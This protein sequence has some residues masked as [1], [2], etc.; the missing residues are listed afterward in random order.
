[1]ARLEKTTERLEALRSLMDR[2][3][4]PDLMLPEAKVLRNRLSVLLAQ[5]DEPVE[6]EHDPNPWS[7]YVPAQLRSE[8]GRAGIRSPHCIPC[9]ACC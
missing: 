8:K 5:E 1:M 2:L 4:A 9:L 7:S 6:V 3:C